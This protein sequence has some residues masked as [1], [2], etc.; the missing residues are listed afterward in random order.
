MP[1]IKL[2]INL[3]NIKILYSAVNNQSRSCNC[4]NKT[5]YPLSEITVYEA[6]INSENFQQ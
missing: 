1:D 4:I 3:H 6:D 2:T 5:N